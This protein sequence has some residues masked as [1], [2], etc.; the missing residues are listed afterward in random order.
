MVP[1]ERARFLKR[2]LKMRVVLGMTAISVGILL[3]LS[4]VR[5]SCSSESCQGNIEVFI[6]MLN[7]GD[8]G[9]AA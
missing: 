1:A 6:H 2:G 9:D 5:T 3:C 7:V 8:T 4:P